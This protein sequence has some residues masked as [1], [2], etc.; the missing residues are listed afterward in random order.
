MPEFAG[1]AA[2]RHSGTPSGA[3]MVLES[4]VVR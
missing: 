2:L 3:A 4:V 1:T